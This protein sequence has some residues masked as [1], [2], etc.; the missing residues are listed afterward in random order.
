M[1]PDNLFRTIKDQNIIREISRHIFV[2]K[3]FL[4]G[5]A[6]RE[7]LLNK[8]PKDYDFALT[9]HD[10]LHVFENTFG[11]HAFLLGKKPIQTYRVVSRDISLDLTFLK[12]TIEEDLARR[13]FTMNAIAYDIGEN[14]IIDSLR[15]IEDIDARII[16]YPSRQTLSD[17]PLRMLKAV[18]H[19]ATLEG[20]TMDS[21]LVEAIQA[22]KHLIH[23]VAPERIRHEMD[24]IVVSNRAVEGLKMLELVGLLFE[25]FPDLY[26]LKTL[27]EEKQFVLGTFGHTIDGFKYLPSYARECCLD[28]KSL[29]NVAYALLLH[30]IGKAHTFSRDDVKKVVHFFY[31]E[32]F[33]CDLATH[34]MERL[35][36]SSL[37]IKTIIK[38]IENHMRIFLISNSESTE[39]AMRRI[40]YKVGELTPD[41]V[42]LTL[43]DLY[44]SSG[45]SENDSTLMVRKRCDDVLGT[46]NEW[47]KKPLPRLVTGHDLLAI[48]LE[49]GPLIGRILND[50]REK[51][52]GGELTHKEEA[53]SYARDQLKTLSPELINTS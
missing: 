6:I 50:I 18:R 2:G 43:C 32:K 23:T 27:D 51:Q 7:L 13:D 12:G 17:D 47:R 34:I 45:G 4:V 36:F 33:S 28:E 14:R 1:S 15:G 10:D 42:V 9:H 44:G 29:R 21:E 35:R 11:T 46:Y 30:D 48:G 25:L 26:A 52:I 40:V 39:K 16:R 37:D 41:L 53:F 20:F 22:L 5:G 38:L 8:A 3:V 31:H 19:F 24:Q 49:E